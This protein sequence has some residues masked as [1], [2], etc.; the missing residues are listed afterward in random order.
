MPSLAPAAG[1]HAA[2]ARTA[3]SAQVSP[4]RSRR[5]MDMAV[6]TGPGAG[7]RA[8]AV[9]GRVIEFSFALTA[10]AKIDGAGLL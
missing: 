7:S 2:S 4:R 1:R 3:E 8:Q 6:V 5:V 9:R 10:G